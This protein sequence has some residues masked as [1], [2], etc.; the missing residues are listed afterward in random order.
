MA[1]RIYVD[2]PTVPTVI[3]FVLRIDIHMVYPLKNEVHSASDTHMCAFY[4][5][6]FDRENYTITVFDIF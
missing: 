3:Y 4:R 6:L 1:S 2:M 5:V